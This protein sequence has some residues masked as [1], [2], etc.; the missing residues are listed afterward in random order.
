[1]FRLIF[2]HGCV[3]LCAFV[4][5]ALSPEE[6]RPTQ[7]HGA[8]PPRCTSRFPRN[9][10]RSSSAVHGAVSLRCTAQFPRD[11]R[12]GSPEMRRLSRRARFITR[13]SDGVDLP[14]SCA[15]R[16]KRMTRQ[17]QHCR[18]AGLMRT[19]VRQLVTGLPVTG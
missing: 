10:L 4:R 14:L 5:C 12:L 11:A 6:L 1:M 18:H 9:A 8:V 13:E 7:L 17:D 2:R 16:T 3:I 19:S 15:S